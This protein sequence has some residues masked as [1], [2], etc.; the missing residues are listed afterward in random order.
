MKLRHM[1]TNIR[2]SIP[3]YLRSNSRHSAANARFSECRFRPFCVNP[4]T[5]SY[6]VLDTF[7]GEASGIPDVRYD[8][9]AACEVADALNL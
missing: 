4:Q 8:F 7:D 5:G 3:A 9:E 1:A 2:S 6:I